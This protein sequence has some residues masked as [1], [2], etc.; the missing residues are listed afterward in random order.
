LPASDPGEQRIAVY[1]G[2]SGLI[3]GHLGADDSETPHRLGQKRAAAHDSANNVECHQKGRLT[4]PTDHSDSTGTPPKAN[5]ARNPN[6]NP[7]C[8]DWGS[9]KIGRFPQKEGLSVSK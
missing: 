6:I 9:D 2:I 3:K 8:N 5:W 7:K 4:I 1:A